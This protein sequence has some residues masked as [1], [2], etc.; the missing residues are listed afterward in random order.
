MSKEEEPLLCPLCVEEL[1]VTDRSFNPC[2]CG[3]Q[4]CLWCWHSINEELNGLCPACR[5]PYEQDRAK[6][7]D[8]A[9]VEAAQ[10]ERRKKKERHRSD[11]SKPS[12]GEGA[13]CTLIEVH[14]LLLHT[15]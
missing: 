9:L 14:T 6:Q 11:K 8:P 3:Y 7:V 15:S 12:S 2:Q 10:A 1:D 13:V 5:Q 4:V